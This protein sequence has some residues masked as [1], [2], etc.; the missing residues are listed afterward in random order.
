MK[1]L[2]LD[3]ST[4]STGIAI[5]ENQE[6]IFYTC[7]Q[8]GSANL[9]KRIDKMVSEIDKILNN[10]NIDNIIIEDVVP[11]DVRHNQ[12]VYKPLIYLQGFI[13]HLLNRHGFNKNDIKFYTASEWRKK[14]GIHTGR[15]I[16]RESL[17]P[18]D[19]QFVKDQFEISV[20]DDIADAICIGFAAVGGVIKKPQTIIDESDFEFA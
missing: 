11:D 19:I 8:A 10:Y 14:C 1:T 15:G 5:F 18:R 9:Y 12:T 13:M 3:L 17:K 2:S 16:K 6:L 20:N 7:I 4:K